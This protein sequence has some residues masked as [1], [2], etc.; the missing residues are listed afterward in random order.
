VSKTNQNL[1]RE[2]EDLACDFLRK[3]GYGIIARN[4]RTR[5]G[6]IDII[7]SDKEITC[8]IEVKTRRQSKFGSPQEAVVNIKKRHMAKAATYYLVQHNMLD[9]L[10]RFDVVS[11][12]LTRDPAGIELI[13]CAFQLDE[14][15]E[16][17]DV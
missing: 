14:N 1:G 5:A 13:K 17:S 3:A 6:E 12:D 7:A 16:V 10:C 2:G 9:S 11:V 15:N 8:F 4:Y